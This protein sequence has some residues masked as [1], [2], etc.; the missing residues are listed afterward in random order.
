MSFVKSLTGNNNTFAAVGNV[1]VQ[2]APFTAEAVSKAQSTQVSKVVGT[3]STATSTAV[4]TEKFI[5]P[6]ESGEMK[7]IAVDKQAVVNAVKAGVQI[8]K[9]SNTKGV[10]LPAFSSKNVIPPIDVAESFSLTPWKAETFHEAT[11]LSP[12]KPEIIVFTYFQPLFDD[13]GQPTDANQYLKTRNFVSNLQVFNA[14]ASMKAI[15]SQ[16]EMSELSTAPPFSKSLPNTSQTSML[17]ANSFSFASTTKSDKLTQ[18]ESAVKT[19]QSQ[20]NFLVTAH[21][22]VA[23]LKIRLDLRDKSMPISQDSIALNV[24]YPKC[25]RGRPP[26]ERSQTNNAKNLW[27]SGL[28]GSTPVLQDSFTA[29]DFLS[30]C[31]FDKTKMSSWSSSRVWAQLVHEVGRQLV[32]SGVNT[33]QLSLSQI[34]RSKYKIDDNQT[35]TNVEF[36]PISHV[37]LALKSSALSSY[38]SMEFLS[39]VGTADGLSDMLDATVETYKRIDVMAKISSNAPSRVSVILD[40]LSK[41]Y[42]YS[43][44]VGSQSATD[45]LT[46]SFG[47]LMPNSL[48]TTSGQSALTSVFGVVVSDVFSKQPFNTKSLATLVTSD[49]TTAGKQETIATFEPVQLDD[50]GSAYTLIPGGEFYAESVFNIHEG[51]FNT[52]ALVMLMTKMRTALSDVMVLVN[53]GNF[54]ALADSNTAGVALED[55]SVVVRSILGEVLMPDGSINE[56]YSISSAL[57]VE[58]DAKNAGLAGVD[59]LFPKAP[60]IA[61][62]EDSLDTEVPVE[63]LENKK[64]QDQLIDNLVV[65]KV[66][67]VRFLALL[68]YA[69]KNVYVKSFLF[70]LIMSHVARAITATNDTSTAHTT[71]VVDDSAAI[72]IINLI[73]NDKP[74]NVQLSSIS[75]SVLKLTHDNLNGTFGL[76]DSDGSFS[77]FVI[78]FM[79]SVLKRVH[80][81][82]FISTSKSSTALEDAFSSEEDA[83]YQSDPG[84]KSI[85]KYG[86]VSDMAYMSAMFDVFCSIAE[87]VTEVVIA[88]RFTD[89][90]NAVSGVVMAIKKVSSKDAMLKICS[91]VDRE[92]SML[93]TSVTVLVGYMHDIVARAQ[94]LY[95]HLTSTAN[96]QNLKSVTDTIGDPR[97]I[98]SAIG[99]NQVRLVY[100]SLRDLVSRLDYIKAADLKGSDDVDELEDIVLDDCVLSED[101]YAMLLATFGTKE[102]R[103]NAGFN[104]R[105]L[106]VGVP[107]GLMQNL[108]QRIDVSMKNTKRVDLTPK[109]TDIVRINVYKVDLE[110]SDLVFKPI[111]FLFEMSKFVSR[112]D[113]EYRDIS[114]SPSFNDVVNAVPLIDLGERAWLSAPIQFGMDSFSSDSYGFLSQSQKSELLKNH[115]MSHMIELYIRLMCG[116]DID[117]RKFHVTKPPVFLASDVRTKF[118][119]SSLLISTNAKKKST[120]R[121]TLDPSRT[122]FT[123]IEPKNVK[124]ADTVVSYQ[125]SSAAASTIDISAMSRVAGDFMTQHVSNISSL[126]SVATR[127]SDASA[128]STSI[129]VPKKFDRVFNIVVDPDDFV[130]DHTVT[131]TSVSGKAMF[132]KLKTDS[133]VYDS[134]PTVMSNIGLLGAEEVTAVDP[135]FKVKERQKNEGD[136]TFEKYFVTIDTLVDEVL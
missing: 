87:Q 104:K 53:E 65:S 100:R 57:A 92:L 108:K 136:Y 67:S 62:Q 133:V 7:V 51:V 89:D 75:S 107:T 4:S 21:D 111:S 96:I 58:I 3:A 134:R 42:R 86:R 132:D 14:V 77:K 46:T 129:F 76:L 2:S 34:V 32:S 36:P 90:V 131:W 97:L 128:L 117:E 112:F 110:Y 82:S 15:S 73:L 116:V 103:Q 101:Q 95:D 29:L 16:L 13:G 12:Y 54:L 52:A 99:E 71:S 106:S 125:K 40:A 94:N 93:R 72:N 31:G 60:D 1:Q 70:A 20:V 102:F 105:L 74:I 120:L 6:T 130:I 10:V 26:V 49:V 41:D 17:S 79:T 91:A 37:T 48:A 8:S 69:N 9:S 38:H 59:D 61:M 118:V 22:M 113:K 35:L 11:G 119:D 27:I 44:M 55:Q 56:K 45:V 39:R 88:G 18:L 81:V 66:V 47:A 124:S 68:A 135:V 25:K 123:N 19:L 63:E 122:L 64:L 30:L 80:S 43:V 126:F 114:T 85:T 83:M 28:H 98:Q 115:I 109:Q 127:F 78:D 84:F 50:V 24:F 5:V 33:D 23:A 121:S